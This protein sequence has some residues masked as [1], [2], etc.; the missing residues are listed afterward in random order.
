LGPLKGL[1]KRKGR[2]DETVCETGDDG[3][4]LMGVRISDGRAVLG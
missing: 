2:I 4:D 3:G 1:K